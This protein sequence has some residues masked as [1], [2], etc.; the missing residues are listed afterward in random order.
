MKRDHRYDCR[1]MKPVCPVNLING[2]EKI[3]QCC[4]ICFLKQNAADSTV[5][6]TSLDTKYSTIV[7]VCS[8][9]IHNMFVIT[10]YSAVLPIE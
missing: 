8:P 3:E 10:Q 4:A 9:N 6:A 7:S 1:L 2:H 5:T